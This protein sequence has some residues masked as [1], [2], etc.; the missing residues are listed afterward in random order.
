M[1][2]GNRRRVAVHMGTVQPRLLAKARTASAGDESRELLPLAASDTLMWRQPSLWKSVWWLESDRGTHLLL[3]MPG[4]P[5]FRTPRDCPVEAA[6]GT[7][8][9]RMGWGLDTQATPLR[10][11]DGH[12]LM[13]F[14][15]A[16]FGGGKLVTSDAVEL[17]WH[18]RGLGSRYFADSEGRE[19][20]RHERLRAWGAFRHEA[21]VHVADALIQRDD[22]LPLL[23]LAWY[24]TL[25]RRR[26]SH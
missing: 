13:R 14:E 22:M 17:P 20:I 5:I 12:E 8:S 25:D 23:A 9:I 4:N 19:M 16:F 18:R 11:A 3:H 7:W 6:S 26:K 2:F 15:P 24:V 1:A 21:C 10:D